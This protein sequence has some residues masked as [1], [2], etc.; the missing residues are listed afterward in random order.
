[1]WSHWCVYRV[2]LTPI[3]TVTP[4]AL[5]HNRS[6]SNIL[7]SPAAFPSLGK[8]P[9]LVKCDYLLGP[10]LLATKQQNAVK[11]AADHV[12]TLNLWPQPSVDPASVPSNTSNKVTL[13]GS[14]LTFSYLYLPLKSPLGCTLSGPQDDDIPSLLSEEITVSFHYQLLDS[15]AS[16]PTHTASSLLSGGSVTAS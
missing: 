15:P 11:K 10:T 6:L 9:I 8:T 13:S 16:G 2:A 14:G 5:Y 12:V 4:S 7:N 3:P 1:M